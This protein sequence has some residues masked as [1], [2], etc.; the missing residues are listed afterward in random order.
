MTGQ[1]LA[2]QVLGLKAHHAVVS[3][4]KSPN[5]LIRRIHKLTQL[6]G[7]FL[8]RLLPTQQVLTDFKGRD[9]CHAFGL[10]AHHCAL[11]KSG[12]TIDVSLG[13]RSISTAWLK[14]WSGK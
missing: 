3:V 1:T 4:R 13:S 11:K 10:I 14:N 5:G 7:E 8:H 12:L 6:D 2:L 9:L